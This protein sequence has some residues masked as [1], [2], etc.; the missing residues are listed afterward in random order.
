[1]SWT[2]VAKVRHGR[3]RATASATVATVADAVALIRADPSNGVGAYAPSL[4][5]NRANVAAF[6][7]ELERDGAAAFGWVDYTA[8]RKG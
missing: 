5:I 7:A 6:L 4:S 2:V 1:M 3:H 8:T